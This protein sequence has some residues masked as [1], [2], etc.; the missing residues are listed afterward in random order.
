MNLWR[1][2]EGGNA[3][4]LQTLLSYNADDINGLLA[5]KRYL[6]NQGLLLRE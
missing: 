3:E 6:A 4:A 5:I 1:D 2:H